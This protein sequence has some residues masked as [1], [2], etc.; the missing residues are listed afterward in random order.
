MSHFVVDAIKSDTRYVGS[1]RR[2]RAIFGIAW[3]ESRTARRR[4]LLYMSSI[5]LG[6][7]AL[8]AIDSFSDNVIRSVHEQSRALLGGDVQVER[9]APR[10]KA[11]DSLLDSLSKAGIVHTTATDFTSMALVPR[12]GGTRLVQVHAIAKGYPYY[13]DII[14]E[15]ASAWGELQNGNNVIVDPALI[16]SLDAKIGDSLTLGTGTFVITGTLKSVPGDVGFSAA[17]GPRI[18]MPERFV[19]QTG[20]VTFGSRAQFEILFKLPAETP[21]SPFV[22]R[23]SKRMLDSTNGAMRSAG[24]NESR[25]AGA[26][27]EL[28]DYLAVVGLVALL[29]GG[30]GVASGVHAFV[31]KKIDPVAILRCLGATSWQVLAIYT[32]QAAVMGFIGALGGVVLGIVIQFVMPYALKDFLPVDV[33]VRLAPMAI[34]VGLGVGVW[35]ALLFSLRPLVALRRVSPL[36]ALRREPDADALRR[37]R[38]DP[39][40]LLLSFAIGA[41]VLGLSLSRANTV[42]R[43]VGFAVAIGVAIGVLWLSAVGL[44]WL[45]R[46]AI[47]PSWPFPIRQGVASLYRPGNQTRAVVLALGFGVFLMGTLYQVQYNILRSLDLRLGEAR[48]NVVFFDVQET[49]RAGIDS[50]IRSGGNELIDETPIVPMRISSINGTPLADLLT[51]ANRE[52]SD[53]ARKVNRGQRGA[54]PWALRREFR[55]TFR[56]SLT[57]SERI[58]AG[59]WFAAHRADSLGEVSLD[60]SVAGG[61][62]VHLN[63]TITWNVQGVLIPTVITSYREVKWQTFSP[64]FFAV[65]NPASLEKAPKQFVIQVR[66]RDPTSIAHLQRDVVAKFPGVSS[67]DLT[68]IQKTVTNVLGKVTM[69][70]RFLALISLALG[71]PVLFSA[72]AATR[73]ERLREGVLLKTLGATRKQIGRIMLAEYL[74][75]GTLGA[76][77]GVVLSTAAGW[78]LMHWIFRFPF[79]PAF[80]PVSLVAGAMISLAVAIGLLTGRDVFAETPMAALRE[81]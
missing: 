62:G 36:Q 26:I 23:F 79:V 11:V 8:V 74:L 58:V 45:A 31:M 63:D 39:L 10:T 41:S 14:T 28:H 3:R 77:T 67:L 56:D 81:T 15:P 52:R 16:V 43:G 20:L 18:Y 5:S 7:A 55:S 70:V 75:L 21:A 12:S 46:R 44:S 50:I 73:R 65:F 68:L 33:E 24:Y 13:G 40:R 72:V 2:T 66:S 76:L 48:S 4:L 1:S 49:Q 17:I 34:L 60:T 64:N 19:E 30:I 32:A 69:A 9:N 54:R 27:D 57:E 42:K 59:H 47:R 80:G 61:L 51:A 25:L 78:A 22:S 53:S 71:I 37:A 6:V 35:V 29:L 38:W